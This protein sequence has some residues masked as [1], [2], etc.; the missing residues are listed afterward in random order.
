MPS[1]KI[2]PTDSTPWGDA[3]DVFFTPSRIIPSRWNEVYPYR[4]LVVDAMTNKV[5]MMGGSTFKSESVDNF[6]NGEGFLLT[7]SIV[8]KKWELPLPITPQQLSIQDVYAISNTP[9]LRG[10][11][12][13]HNGIK[14][15]NISMSGTF[16]ILTQRASPSSTISGTSLM[17]SLFAG[18]LEAVDTLTRTAKKLSNLKGHPAE[19]ERGASDPKKT[20]K[21]YN[22]G[23]Y[24]AMYAGRFLE[25]YAIAKKN[26][27]NSNWRL[28]LDMPKRNE[29]YIVTPVSYASSQSINKPAEYMWQMQLKAWKRIDLDT[30]RDPQV[31]ADKI[32]L[33]KLQMLNNSLRTL[34]NLIAQS[35]DVVKA[36]RADFQA[37]MNTLR[38]TSLLVKDTA[39]LVQTSIDLI[40]AIIKDSKDSISQIG[41]DLNTSFQIPSN[42]A[43]SLGTQEVK[44]AHTVT[45]IKGMYSKNEGL[46]PTA[47]SQSDSTKSASNP[48]N[49]GS[50]GAS[51]TES[52]GLDQV[53][54]NPEANFG[55]FNKIPLAQVNLTQ[56]Q[57][58][59]INDEMTR[60]RLTNT[61][62]L[63]RTKATLQSVAFDLANHYG[64]GDA[65]VAAVYGRPTPNTR[66]APMTIEENE[67]IQA[68]YEVIAGL[69]ALT[70]SRQFDTA[71]QLNQTS[72]QLIGGLAS[73]VDIQIDT[74]NSKYQAPVPYGLSIEQIAM[75]YL[76]SPDKWIEIVTINALRE[77]YIDE[78]GFFYPL[79]SNADG[80]SFTV[81]D[82]ESKLFIGQK[83]TLSDLTTLPFVRTISDIN[84]ISDVSYLVTVNGNSDLAITT[85]NGAKLQAYLPGTVNSQNIIYIP[86]N[87]PSDPTSDLFPIPNLTPDKLNDLANVDFLLDDSGDIAVNSIGDFRLSNGLT[88][89]IQTLKLKIQTKKG[90]L[91]RHE[92][93]GL[94]ITA[95]M[96]T[97]DI[98][99][100][101]LIRSLNEMIAEDPR[102]E[103]ISTIQIT[104]KENTLNINMVVNL[105]NRTGVLPINFDTKI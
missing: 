68:L 58:D 104:L 30:T 23:Y 14:Y 28:V 59:D 54:N 43:F 102:F 45:L 33:N 81:N 101:E 4:L 77:P 90:S 41:K 84:K 99:S 46:S 92:N 36:V 15:K 29:S 31:A 35:T 1:L 67:I 39:G 69:D 48:L 51:P 26:P 70:S 86:S 55:F 25:Q 83:I 73:N 60:I 10:I 53:F 63:K 11:V 66:T 98:D 103:S 50:K 22:T 44:A 40:P 56:N 97:A 85:T 13:E 74:Y 18:T 9:T 80:R 72:L 24:Y 5:I 52:N 7:Q 82:S 2:P 42:S 76:K 88:N 17:G 19:I 12:E 37:V 71:Q 91:L 62:D 78:V 8:D 87:L 32:S 61:A 95:G 100:G 57:R 96:S 105:A 75:R 20:N 65:T 6:V 38:Q 89:L 94:G 64:A 47:T 16:G 27:K 93:Y 49:S 3:N 34:R 79:L 21:E